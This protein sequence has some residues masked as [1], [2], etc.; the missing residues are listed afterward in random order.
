MIA[1]TVFNIAIH[2]PEKEME[3]LY[4]MLGK[5]ITSVPKKRKA[6]KIFITEEEAREHIYRKV[7][8]SNGRKKI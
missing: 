6:S 7:F 3:K 5:K 8:C 4:L 1:E 2:L